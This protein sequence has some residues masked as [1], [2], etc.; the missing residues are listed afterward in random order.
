MLVCDDLKQALALWR[1]T[2]TDKTI[3]T[4]DGEVI[5]PHGVVTGGSREHAVAGILSQKREIRELE[6]VVA[7]VEA[8][9]EAARGRQ[10]S[11]K[12]SLAIATAQLEAIDAEVREDEVARVG[13]QKDLDRARREAEQLGHRRNQL[14]SERNEIEAVR[15]RTEERIQVAREALD[16]DRR[17]AVDAEALGWSCERRPWR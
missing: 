14:A 4:L 10:I 7:R 12:Q 17:A 8:D 6:E 5:D 11:L 1:E 15:L 16:A 9:L 2:H 3:V 13:E